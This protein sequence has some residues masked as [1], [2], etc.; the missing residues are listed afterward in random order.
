MLSALPYVDCTYPSSPYPYEYADTTQLEK[1]LCLSIYGPSP[2][3]QR[4]LS[5]QRLYGE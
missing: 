4:N 5:Q 1:H 2:S 3:P